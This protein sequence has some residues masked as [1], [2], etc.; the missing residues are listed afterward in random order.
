MNRKRLILWSMLLGVV[1]FP[2]GATLIL[3]LGNNLLNNSPL[4]SI[5]PYFLGFLLIG[6]ILAF[7][8]YQSKKL[9]TTSS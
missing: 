5:T 7:I 9:N 8:M 1:V 3:L 4:S 2:I 6:L